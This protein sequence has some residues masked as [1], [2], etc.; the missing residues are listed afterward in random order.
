MLA[1]LAAARERVHKLI[2][3]REPAASHKPDQ[4][5]HFRQLEKLAAWRRTNGYNNIE[6][7]DERKHRTQ[8]HLCSVDDLKPS[9]ID[10]Y[11]DR[12]RPP[13]P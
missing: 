2:R 10:V 8:G 13:T 11:F 9:Q 3:V 5:N 7:Q 6:V 1:E 12:R 4:I